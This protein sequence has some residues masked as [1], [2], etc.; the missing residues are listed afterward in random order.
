MLKALLT[1]ATGFIGSRLTRRLVDAGHSV[2]ILVRE[3]SRTDQLAGYL[4]RLRLRVV[5]DTTECLRR[6]VAFELPDVVFHLAT[7]FARD[8][9]PED[10][11]PMIEANITFPLRL[12]DAMAREG[13]QSLVNTG[14]EWQYFAGSD[15]RPVCLHSATKQAFEALLAY[16]VDAG[17]I[18]CTTLILRDT[19][20]AGDPRRKIFSI[21][22][23]HA[24]LSQPLD[25]SAGEQLVD[26]VHVDDAVSAFELAAQRLVAGLQTA[27][28]E[29]YSVRGAQALPLR[30]IVETYLRL[31]NLDVR[32]RWGGRPYHPREVMLPW[33]GGETVPGWRPQI[34]IADGL[35]ELAE[36]TS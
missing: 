25:M 8:H 19:Y 9:R 11:N 5:D 33:T 27:G 34:D 36:A 26:L 29:V 23:E 20:G 10:L 1:G 28:H 3:S 24:G 15:Y 17:N 13:V 35:K 7:Y 2:A 6:V 18:R 21:L 31:S 4:D 32:I 12:V 22:R 30:Q 16:F 14:S